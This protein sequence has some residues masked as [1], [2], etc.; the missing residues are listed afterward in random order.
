MAVLLPLKALLNALSPAHL[1]TG[2]MLERDN[3]AIRL[4]KQERLRTNHA[5]DRAAPSSGNSYLAN[6]LYRTMRSSRYGGGNA[7]QHETL[8][9]VAEPR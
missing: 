1:R 2:V 9:S 6:D 8:K 7:S 5:N 3:H 4:R